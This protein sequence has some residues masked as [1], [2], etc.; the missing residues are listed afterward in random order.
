MLFYIITII[1]GIITGLFYT[2]GLCNSVMALLFIFALCFV[3]SILIWALPCVIRAMFVSLDK[4]CAKTSRFF[5]F[6]ANCIIA[7][8]RQIFRIKICVTGIEQLP[9]EKF[10]LVGNH[11]SPLDPILEMGVFRDFH[12]GFVAKQELY[13][14]PV[15]RKIMHKCFCLSLDRSDPRDGIRAISQAAEIIQSQVASIGIYPEGTCNKGD[16][17]LPFKAG[18]FKIA[19]K[20]ACPIVVVI[21]RDSEKAAHAPFKKTK[22]FIDVIGVISAGEVSESKSTQM[23]SDRVRLMMES[24]LNTQRKEKMYE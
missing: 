11:R 18:A 7:S 1:S 13:K 15:V 12:I 16:K 2:A 17:L 5:R 22:V 8:I 21:I 14:I 9:C 3:V 6:Y 20:A 23:L 24:A 4:P 19:Q 10:L